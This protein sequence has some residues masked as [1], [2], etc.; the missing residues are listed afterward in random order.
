MR[1]KATPMTM[2]T[3]ALNTLILS[4]LNVRTT[5]RNADIEAL[6]EDI[7]QRGL[8]QN[9]VVI[10][11]HFMT[12]EADSGWEDKWEV[13]AGG[14]RFQAM[15]WLVNEG[16]LP[17]DHPVACLLEDRDD[18][19]ETSLSENLHK[20]AMNPADEFAAFKA[21][22]D[23]R[24]GSKHGESE[25]TAI[26]Y[27]AKRFGATV[28]HVE[29]RLRL[30]TLAPEILDAL[31]ANVTGIEAA[32]AYATTADHDLQRKVFALIEKDSWR[33][34][35][36]KQIRDEI[37]GKTL[38]LDAPLVQFVGLVTYQ[39]E[40]GRIEAEMF[41]GDNGQ[42]RLVD[43]AL[44]EKLARKIAEAAIPA[45]AK[46]DGVKEGLYAPGIG[47]S[48]KWP[49]PPK[50]FE[51]EWSFGKTPPKAQ[52]KKS[53]G[54]YGLD[55]VQ[56]DDSDE[57][58]L[59]LTQIGR[60]KPEN[61]KQATTPD[62]DWEA[63]HAANARNYNIGMRA[64]RLAVPQL[65]GGLLKGTELD[66]QTFWPKYAPR[67]IEDDPADENFI[68]VALQVRIP[69]AAADAL[70]DEAARQL[71]AEEAAK[72]AADDDDDGADELTTDEA[73]TDEVEA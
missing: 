66:G 63:E 14:R 38:P 41:M 33:S 24:M 3:L 6:A 17:A 4:K 72:Q 65:T 68:L 1:T 48:A 7:A 45:L 39:A 61:Q 27:T 31:R 9:L 57:R 26:A 32:K 23:Q 58:V 11:A 64:A 73:P 62:R 21:I 42:Q 5:E 34:H 43:V 52:I 67:Q 10:P 49:K 16:R 35:T 53:I 50:G 69:R 60:F 30:A 18:A 36:P 15:Q 19:S 37:R 70:R 28:R 47:Y 56:E 46:K 22:I 55:W 40:G 20:V 44:L 54:V 2:Q 25:A 71:D 29:G 12:G 13:I 59:R 51:K 8:K